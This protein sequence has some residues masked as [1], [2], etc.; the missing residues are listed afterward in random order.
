MS[1]HSR[2]RAFLR[3]QDCEEAF[4]RAYYQYNDFT[5]LDEALW[6]VGN[7]EYIFAHAFDWRTTPEGR[8]F[9]L[10]IDR[11]WNRLLKMNL[12]IR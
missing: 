2:F 8:E 4:D 1:S 7:A 3:E 9:W 6:E 10:K 11:K 5:S 12:S